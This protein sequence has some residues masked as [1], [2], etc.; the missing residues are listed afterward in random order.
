MEKR[1]TTEDTPAS[2]IAVIGTGR[3]GLPLA[4][5]LRSRSFEVTGIDLDER[6]RTL[7][8][9]G[10][11]P[12][13]ESGCDALL[14]EYG[15]P[16]TDDYAALADVDDVIITV[17][18]PLHQ[19]IEVDL[20]QVERVMEQ[21]LPYL[22]VGHNLILR[23][24]VA[25]RT[26]EYVRRL[27][28]QRTPWR[29]GRDIGLSFCPERLA[30]GVALQELESIP[31]ILGAEDRMS[32]NRTTALFDRIAPQIFYCDYVSA[33]LAKLFC[34]TY[35]YISFA[36]ANQFALI[37]DTY[38]SDVHQ[39]LS[40][41]NHEYPRGPIPRPGFTAGTCLRKDFGM[42]NEAI[43][44]PD[45]LLSAWKINEFMPNF[46]VQHA[47]QRVPL[48][49]SRIAVLGYAFKKNSDDTRDSLVPKLLRYLKRENPASIRVTD[50]HLGPDLG[51]YEN[52]APEA[53]AE[54]AQIIFVA[55]NHSCFR[56]ALPAL[57]AKASPEAWIVDL[58]N[59]SGLGR[60]FYR[61]ALVADLDL[62]E[63]QQ[64]RRAA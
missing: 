45:L 61:A 42:I 26:T 5:M 57:A 47:K 43:P 19:H 2:R 58:W 32:A 39:V 46:L 55:T 15:L 14:A 28:H 59:I 50:P 1:S 4:L 44:Y 13:E 51:G 16:M 54:D 6:V 62:R 56:E 33:E 53:A 36:T 3:V 40:M 23:S 35:R 9:A 63:E 38:G 11:M 60:I 7:V 37:A 22:R 34:N 8:S 64:Q 29:V 18:T 25:P 52:Q 17:G 27:I 49:G 48:Y 10:C 20:S 24:T 31:Q 30:E 12:F 21:V 41:A